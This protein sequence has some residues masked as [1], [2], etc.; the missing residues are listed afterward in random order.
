[1]LQNIFRC[2][3][4]GVKK[5]L[6]IPSIKIKRLEVV[7]I[8]GRRGRESADLV[9]CYSFSMCKS[10]NPSRSV[11]SGLLPNCCTGANLYRHEVTGDK[12]VIKET[13]Q[14]VRTALN[15]EVRSNGQRKSLL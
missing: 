12:W 1:M 6:N 14:T 3:Q 15:V 13:K 8:T 10:S 7:K 9:I 11:E 4:G 5:S 2:S